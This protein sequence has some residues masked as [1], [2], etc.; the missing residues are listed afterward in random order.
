LEYGENE[1]IRT[2]AHHIMRT[3]NQMFDL[4]TN[5]LNLNAIESGATPLRPVTI[6]VVPI[7][8]A[9]GEIYALN[10]ERKQISFELH[11]PKP[12]ISVYADEIALHQIIENLASNAVKYASANTTVRMHIFTVNGTNLHDIER[13]VQRIGLPL[14]RTL[15]PNSTILAV[16]DEGPG[17]APKDI[18]LLFTKFRKLSSQPT[19]GETSSGLGLSIVKRLVEG[20]NGRVW[21]DSEFGNGATFFVELP[22]SPETLPTDYTLQPSIDAVLM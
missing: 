16:Q 4:V 17:I 2:I 9:L 12:R 7:L 1:Q 13:S 11:I 5:L 14:R 20:M 3:S 22:T 15:T 18:P 10:A 21:C 19:G 8:Q 6:N